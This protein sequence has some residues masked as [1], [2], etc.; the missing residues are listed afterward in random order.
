MGAGR[1]STTPGL[2]RT[3]VLV[4]P[5]NGK[6]KGLGRGRARMLVCDL[7]VP[8]SGCGTL[9]SLPTSQGGLEDQHET[10]LAS[11]LTG[12]CCCSTVFQDVPGFFGEQWGRGPCLSPGFLGA[13]P[14]PQESLGPCKSPLPP[15][16]LEHWVRDLQCGSWDRRGASPGWLDPLGQ[17]V[18]TPRERGGVGSV[19][20]RRPTNPPNLILLSHPLAHPHPAP[21]APPS[22][23]HPPVRPAPGTEGLSSPQPHL[24]L[25]RVS[26]DASV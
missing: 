4:I 25:V 26:Q 7:V 2:G 10:L 22:L 23:L 19:F 21:V 11:C 9:G 15:V 1:G 3:R 16:L 6:L 13:L 14:Q 18:R 5:S 24:V 20:L 17:A 8:P 12:I